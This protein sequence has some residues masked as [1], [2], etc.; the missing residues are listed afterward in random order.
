MG[1]SRA[2]TCTTTGTTLLGLLCLTA[3]FAALRCRITAFLKERLISSGKRK[4]L[5][6]ITASKLNIS[7][8]GFLVGLLVA[9]VQPGL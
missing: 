5:S 6:T 4:V 2:V 1:R 8:H 9:I 3:R 7:G